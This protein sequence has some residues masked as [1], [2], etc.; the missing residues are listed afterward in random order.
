MRTRKAEQDRRSFDRRTV[1]RLGGIHLFDLKNVL[2]RQM[3]RTDYY[4]DI[5]WKPRE[6]Q[7]AATIGGLCPAA[8]YGILLVESDHEKYKENSDF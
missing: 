3:S 7:R 2:A 1:L 6:E 8:A 5:F 4:S